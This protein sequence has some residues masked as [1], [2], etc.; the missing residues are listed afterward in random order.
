MRVKNSGVIWAMHQLFMSQGLSLFFKREPHRFRREVHD[1]F[2]ADHLTCEEFERPTFLTRRRRT[3]SQG[4][5][6]GFL[7]CVQDRLTSR[8]WFVFERRVEALGQIADSRPSYG[9]FTAKQKLGDGF[10]GA[11]DIAMQQNVCATKGAE[12][13]LALTDQFQPAFSFG[14]LEFDRSFGHGPNLPQ[15]RT[16]IK[17]RH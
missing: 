6:R 2:V 1:L 7:W 15:P 12:R 11:T 16:F 14:G 17:L 8:T 13:M 4:D 10:M 5:Q 9:I 3:A